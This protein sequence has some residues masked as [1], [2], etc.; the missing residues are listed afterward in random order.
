MNNTS[1]WSEGKLK[2]PCFALLKSLGK[3]R[4]DS[5]NFSSVSF[6]EGKQLL[7]VSVN[8]FTVLKAEPFSL[9][10]AAHTH[11][12]LPIPS[13]FS[14]L[15]ILCILSFWDSIR[16]IGSL[17]EFHSRSLKLESWILDPKLTGPQNRKEHI[18]EEGKG[19]RGGQKRLFC[20]TTISIF[21]Y[22]KMHIKLAFVDHE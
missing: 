3:P 21:G 18:G 11:K 9:S 15:L 2:S 8:Y 12:E 17:P 22:Y 6:C 14:F 5:K 13:A 19:R 16:G 20:L 10:T 1:P 4:A 7:L